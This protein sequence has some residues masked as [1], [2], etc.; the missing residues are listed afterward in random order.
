M[1]LRGGRHIRALALPP[2]EVVLAL[3]PVK[4]PKDPIKVLTLLLRS[5]RPE[6]Q[7]Y[8]TQ[9]KSKFQ[10]TF[11][12][13]L[14]FCFVL[15]S[16]NQQLLLFWDQNSTA[17]ISSL[18]NDHLIFTTQIIRKEA[19]NNFFFNEL[20]KFRVLFLTT[21]TLG[22]HKITALQIKVQETEEKLKFFLSEGEHQHQVVQ[23]RS[24]TV[25]RRQEDVKN[26]ADEAIRKI[27]DQLEHMKAELSKVCEEQTTKMND[28][29]QDQL[30]QLEDEASK[31]QSCGNHWEQLEKTARDLLSQSNTSDFITKSYEF[32]STNQLKRLPGESDLESEKLLYREPLSIK[33][34]SPQDLSVFFQ[35]NLLGFFAS[36]DDNPSSTFGD[37]PETGSFTESLRS[38]T[39]DIPWTHI[40]LVSRTCPT[41]L[42]QQ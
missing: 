5:Q 38:A 8:I 23:R 22:N 40:F 24:S 10:F 39:V 2:L 19:I 25:K 28:S 29:Q 21:D 9:C 30:A 32:L 42:M 11:S 4:T 18:L 33:A 36:K 6:E 1:A 31:L 26:S 20:S 12:T 27:N 15:A 13:P 16:F 35:D 34:F 17:S 37:D 3:P 7:R 41:C 14:N